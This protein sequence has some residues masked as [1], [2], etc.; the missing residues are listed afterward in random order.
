MTFLFTGCGGGGT[1]TVPVLNNP[2]SI[3]VTTPTPSVNPAG[4]PGVFKIVV[5]V[6]ASQSLKDMTGS[7]IPYRST[8]LWVS[9]TGEAIGTAIT[10]GTAISG[11]SYTELTISGVPVGL[12]VATIEVRTASGGG[13]DLLAQRKH[14]FFMPSGGTAGVGTAGESFSMGVAIQGGACVPANID[15]P[16]GTLLFFENQDSVQRTVATNPASI[17]ED[18]YGVTPSGQP[19]TPATYHAESYTFGTAG[20]YSYTSPSAS[21]RVLVYDG[22]HLLSIVDDGAEDSTNDDRNPNSGD[23]TVN[24]TVNAVSARGFG[25]SQTMVNGSVTFTEILE[26]GSPAVATVRTATIAGWNDGAI[27]GSVSLPRGK[28]RVV[29][30]V[31]GTDTTENV[32]YY[33]GTGT[34]TVIAN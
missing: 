32:Y 18:I 10:Q 8:H 26:A 29:V 4:K 17:N 24:F 33:K 11:G 2:E 6:P 1:S 27:T 23:T 9:I 5:Y 20:T 22:P 31:R 30:S 19:N 7:V 21:G 16:T 15:V 34:Y 14:G 28:W 25:T 3:S 13:G 12:N